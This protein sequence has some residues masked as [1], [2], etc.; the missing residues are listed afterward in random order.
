MHASATTIDDGRVRLSVEV[1]EAE[2]DKAL[3]DAISSLSSQLRIPGFRPGRVP[4]QVLEARMGGRQALRA[5]ALREV[6]PG[7][8]A[9]ALS[10][11]F[12]EPISSPDIDITAGESDGPLRF[13]AVVEIRPVVKIAGHNG[14]T[15]TLPALGATPGEVDAQVDRLRETDAELVDVDRTAARGDLVTIDLHATNEAGEEIFA[16][17]DVVYEVGSGRVVEALDDQ[18]VGSQKGRSVT[19]DA[20]TP[21]VGEKALHFA[22]VVKEVKEKRL[23]DATDA[24]VKDNSEFDSLAAL[25]ADLEQRI[26]QV[27]LAQAQMAFRDA[28][29]GAL[30]ELVSDDVAP[31]SLIDEEVRERIHDLQHRLE[32]SK[33]DLGGFL[34]ATGRSEA[35]LVEQLRSDARRSVRIDLALRALVEAQKLYPSDAE[36]DEEI[37]KMALSM[38]TSPAEVRARLGS[39]GRMGA[40][41][42]EVAKSKALIWLLEHISVLDEEG[43]AIDT[44]QLRAGPA[45]LDHNHNHAHEHE[46]AQ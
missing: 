27:K 37:A 44:E 26:G 11:E 31:D 45:G 32:Q 39:A 24:W 18:L 19:F 38:E 22:L 4:R 35:D 13:D 7:L 43:R 1:E 10:A 23:P 34:S 42:S 41:R 33:I 12:L 30:A 20:P 16:S 21:S 28:S 40:L 5:E 3:A 9:E 36:L 46:E 8:Y 29:L 15:I 25:R 17:D 2:V 14:L 6:I